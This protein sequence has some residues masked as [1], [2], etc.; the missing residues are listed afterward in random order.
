MATR[1]P[2]QSVEP[3]LRDLVRAIG[4]SHVV[5]LLAYIADE[6][7]QLARSAGDD[8]RAERYGHDARVLGEAAI[9]LLD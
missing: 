3:L 7:E 1:V 4:F 9:R 5:Y 6:R 8:R 2:E